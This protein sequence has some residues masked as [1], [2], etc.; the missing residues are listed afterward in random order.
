MSRFLSSLQHSR[1]CCIGYTNS[2]LRFEFVYPIQH[3]R[4]CC[5]HH[6][7]HYQT[8]YNVVLTSLIQSWYS[9]N[10][11]RL[12]TQ[13]CNNIVISWLYRTCWNNLATSLIISTRLLQVVNSLFHTCWQLETSS[14]KTTCWRLV[15][16]LVTRC[17]M[18]ACVDCC[19]YLLVHKESLLS[20]TVLRRFWFVLTATMIAVARRRLTRF[21]HQLWRKIW[22]IYV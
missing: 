10:V 7:W 11:T 5:K 21:C 22:I 13:G 17:E 16:K 18:F 9:K 8:C 4:S 14:A 19:M 1:P 6:L 12:T 3:G 15:D 20:F 2:R